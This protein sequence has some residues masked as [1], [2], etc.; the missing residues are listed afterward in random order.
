MEKA[1]ECFGV[2]IDWATV[3]RDHYPSACRIIRR[4][5]PCGLR[6]VYDPEDFVGDALVEMMAN[7]A[8]FVERGFAFLTLVAKRR[9]IDAAR[10][11]RSRLTRLDVD[12]IDRRPAAILEHEAAELREMIL[13][14]ARDPGR[15]HVVDLRSRGHTVPEIAELTGV[16]LRTLQRFLKEFVEANEPF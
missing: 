1:D 12:I 13:G 3:M 11:P 7:P 6:G 10:S 16:G 8:R 14:R 2:P 5:M 15:R 4:L 9:M